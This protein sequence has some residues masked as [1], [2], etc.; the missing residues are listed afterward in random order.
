MTTHRDWFGV[1]VGRRAARI[2][3][4]PLAHILKEALSNSLDAGATA[5]SMVCGP[6][7]GARDG[8]GLMAFKF[9]CADNGSGCGDPEILRRVGSTTSDLH[10]GTRGRFGQGLIDLIAVS[11]SAEIRTLGHRLVFDKDGCRI[12]ALKNRV[13][14]LALTLTLRHGGE[15]FGELDDYFDRVILPDGVA[16]TF[17]GRA[18]GRRVPERLVA[19]V[20]LAT[21]LYDPAKDCVRRCQRA[22]T[23]EIHPRRGGSPTIHELGIPVDAAPWELPFDINV[24]Q[25]TPL[26]A[27]RDMLADK[28]KEK[29][30][31]DLIGHMSDAYIEYMDARGE[32]PAEIADSRRN[33][34]SLSDDARRKL[35]RTVTGADPDDIVRRNP[36]DPDD[37]GE[38]QELES[39]GLAPVNRGSLPRGVSEILASAPTVAARHDELCKAHMG[40]TH[41][42]AETD[43]QRACIAAYEVVAEALLGRRVGF[44]RF[45]G[46][47]CATWDDG[48]IGLNIGAGHLWSDP[49]G[50]ESVGVILHECAHAK[51]SG[52][53]VAFA[54]EV[55]RLGGKLAGWVARNH[56]QWE[57]LRA[58]LYE[59]DTHMTTK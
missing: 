28:Y 52:H 30:I 45:R 47:P 33:A 4:R 41:L 10:A 6:A 19:G 29:L 9:S 53:A 43:H 34:A 37:V 21:V 16:L 44:K 20:K 14:G 24:L 5:V 57:K 40:V 15:G 8:D 1:D 46:G 22:T 7:D 11:E 50:E 27:D 12:T 42:Q 13:S 49:L 17:N 51:V 3:S 56:K 25:K 2:R 18:I 58:K 32:A 59:N 39:R 31:G 54:E 35:V 26:D 48:T 36:L 55:Q 38:S 23:V